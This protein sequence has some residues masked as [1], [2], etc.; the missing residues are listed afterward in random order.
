[1]RPEQLAE[2][3][4]VLYHIAWGGS[5]QSIKENGLL[6]TKS[7]LEFYGKRDSEIRT[8]TQKRR[9]HWRKIDCPGRP[10]A[11]IRDQ[12]P[13][14]DSGLRKALPD[15]VEPSAWYELINSM[16][17]FWPTQKRLK[18]MISAPA[19]LKVEHD[20]LLVDTKK[21]VEL[22]GPNIRLSNINSGATLYKPQPR[23]L[24]LFKLFE[25]YPFDK[26]FHKY[27]LNNA[28]AE[29][30]VLDKV[31]KIREAVIE[32]RHGLA[33]DILEKLGSNRTLF[34]VK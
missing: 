21:L 16:V 25:D 11:V 29:V 12:K 14:T 32:T 9:E 31:D 33:K 24:D 3:Y 4:P 18:T 23:D 28:I 17:F 15:N 26:R 5:W 10:Q 27:K 34:S 6:S 7:L 19:Y 8:F 30:C 2:F 22:E 1:M 20:V 13:L